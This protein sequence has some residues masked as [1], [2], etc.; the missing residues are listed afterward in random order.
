MMGTPPV[1]VP[2][3]GVWLL[4]VD[5]L[6]TTH[7]SGDDIFITSPQGED[8]KFA[9]RFRFK[10]YNNE[11]EYEI[12]VVGMRMT[13]EVGARRL[14]VYSNSQLIVKQAERTYEAK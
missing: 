4:H 5:G 6:A 13:H 3:E 12:P 9:I 11:T 14:M 1:E 7:G 2:E 8:M 10:A